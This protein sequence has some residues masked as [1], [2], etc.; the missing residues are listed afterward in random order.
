MIEFATELTTVLGSLK[1]LMSS[2]TATTVFDKV[3][4]A[5]ANRDKEKTI[6]QLEEIINNLISEKNELIT[7]STTLES[8]LSTKKLSNEEISYIS[9]SIFP[10]LEELTLKNIS[11][12]RQRVA[13]E[14]S[15]QS[16]KP[17]LSKETFVIL[18]SLGF[19]FKEAIGEPLTELVK[20]LISS[21]IPA[22]GQRGKKTK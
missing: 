3:S 2:N 14:N 20:A 21:K 13:M 5:K 4:Q 10:V 18:Q 11:D 9:E 17:L 8:E 12:D 19:N 15:L 16:F 1:N 22:T 7:I 6:Q